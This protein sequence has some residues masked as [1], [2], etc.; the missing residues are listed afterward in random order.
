[1]DYNWNWAVLFQEPYLGW[2]LSGLQWTLLVAIAAWVIAF[3]VGS[4]VGI[5]RT[6]PNRLV[7][8]LAAAYVELFRNIPLLVQ[9]FVWYFV[10]PEL[11]PEDLGLWVKR[12]M[13]NPEYVT[14]V[15]ALG[16]YTAARVAEQVRSGIQTIGKDLVNAGLAIGLTPLQNYLYI[17]LPISYRIIVPPLTS[18]FLTI[19]KNSSLALTIGVLELTAQA[20]QIEN[21]T[22]Q[23][24]EAFTAATVLY[25]VI[26][27]L[28]V[29]LMRLIDQKTRIPGS[30][31]AN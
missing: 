2:L 18:E 7:R 19:F 22:F 26:T 24:F 8:T 20:R 10:V 3:V 28:V 16:A 31:G 13:P 9:L 23:G 25:L 15:V 14:A 4:A 1:M 17:R 29:L 21:Y 27:L 11:L 5:L 30:V 6:V 12:D